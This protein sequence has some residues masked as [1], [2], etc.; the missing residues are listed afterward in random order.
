MT[1]KYHEHHEHQRQV[2][3]VTIL[4]GAGGLAL[5]VLGCVVLP[6]QQGWYLLGGGLASMGLSVALWRAQEWARL[7]CGALTIAILALQLFPWSLESVSRFAES[8]LLLLIYGLYLLL[9]ST[10]RAFA[11]AR[12]ARSREREALR[13]VGGNYLSAN[14]SR[15]GPRSPSHTQRS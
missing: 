6:Q 14:S 8:K 3:F 11:D 2:A 9:P 7:T 15:S 13:G 12:A 1:Q 10:R 4:T 5:L